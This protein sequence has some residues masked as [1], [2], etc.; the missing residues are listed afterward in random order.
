M[1]TRL[2]PVL[3]PPHLANY[4]FLEMLSPSS[5]IMGHNWKHFPSESVAQK[6]SM[7]R[8]SDKKKKN[9]RNHVKI[10]SNILE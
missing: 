1:K 6:K 5:P 9:P 3:G 2:K 4:F 8:N 10:K 7:M